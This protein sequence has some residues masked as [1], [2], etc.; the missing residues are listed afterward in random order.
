MSDSE[1]ELQSEEDDEDYL[2]SGEEAPE[3]A[4]EPEG[5]ENSED[6]EETIETNNVGERKSA[7]IKNEQKKLK[8]SKL[9]RGRTRRGVIYGDN[10]NDNN[11]E[12]LETP[13]KKTKEE[14]EEEEKKH[15][16]DLWSSFLSDVNQPKAKTTQKVVVQKGTSVE[17]EGDSS[18][19]DILTSNVKSTIIG[20]KDCPNALKASSD[21]ITI[22]KV[23][24]FAGEEIKVFRHSAH[25]HISIHFF[26]CMGLF[27]MLCSGILSSTFS[28]IYKALFAHSCSG[29]LT[30]AVMPLSIDL[31]GHTCV[32]AFS[33][34]LTYSC[35][36]FHSL[37]INIK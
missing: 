25:L 20:A 14:A 30:Y 29:I 18:S 12:D 2:P 8:R 34:Q 23:F 6:D 36:P 13:A 28:P 22:T 4:S 35:F 31:F 37:D 1:T 10:S 27:L 3:E 24:D 9:K 19:S 33:I 11:S 15:V 32:P 16:D 5:S 7:R 26:M 17:I 21:K